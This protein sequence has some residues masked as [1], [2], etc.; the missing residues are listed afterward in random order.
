MHRDKITFSFGK[1]WVD[2]V[3]YY[4]NE[5]RIKEAMSSLSRF[6]GLQKLDGLSFLDIGCGSGLFSLAAFRLGA[7]KIVSFDLDPFSVRCCKYLRE[8]EGNP[9]DWT[10]SE[11][12]ILD[13][14]FL[15]RIKKADIV[16]SWGV[17][18]HTGNMWQA[19]RNAAKLVKP[20]GL[21]YIAIYNK[22]EGSFGS[23]TWLELKRFYNTKSKAGKIIIEYVFVSM[24]VLKM[25]ATLKNPFSVIRKY[26]EKR[27]MSFIIDVRDSLGGYPYE[28]ASSGEI[29]N[30]CRKEF[31]FTLENLK[32]VNSLSLN[33]FLFKKP[34]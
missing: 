7:S 23:R 14:S 18:H 9:A 17:L 20:G 30:F 33:E 19:I 21:L 2:F 32:T 27:G 1:N 10:V 29:F 16:Y 8:K 11:G 4:L 28:Y 34:E 3:N 6:L 25:L 13:E 12:S 15:N 26:R 22:V 24:I 5:D 31:G